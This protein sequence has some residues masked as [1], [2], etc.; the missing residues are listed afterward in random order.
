MLFSKANVIVFGIK[1]AKIV[2]SIGKGG[3]KRI[4]YKWIIRMWRDFRDFE[5]LDFFEIDWLCKTHPHWNTASMKPK[6]TLLKW[7]ILYKNPSM[8]GCWTRYGTY[9]LL[10]LGPMIFDID[11]GAD[12]SGIP[13]IHFTMIFNTFVMMTLCNEINAR[14]IHGERNVFVG[15]HRNPIFVIIWIATVA[16]QVWRLCFW[17][18]RKAKS[19]SNAIPKD[20]PIDCL[21]FYSSL[22]IMRWRVRRNLFLY[23]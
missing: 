4:F 14:K 2:Y 10:S 22:L 23:H 12:L 3:K 13:N 8:V 19:F 1:V 7:D 5:A 9:G 15:I 20:S 16:S 18:E 11:D 21:I 17:N 6:I